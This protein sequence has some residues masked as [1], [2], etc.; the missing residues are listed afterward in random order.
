[1]GEI[2]HLLGSCLNK[3]VVNKQCGRVQTVNLV[4]KNCRKFGIEDKKLDQ[5]IKQFIPCKAEL[6]SR[7]TLYAMSDRIFSFQCSFVI[8][9]KYFCS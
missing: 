5:A 1:M 4:L 9:P 3:E 2:T 8:G 7:P 6:L